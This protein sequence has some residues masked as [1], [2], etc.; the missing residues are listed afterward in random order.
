M[1][2]KEISIEEI[3]GYN[4]LIDRIF[5]KPIDKFSTKDLKKYRRAIWKLS[6]DYKTDHIF[7]MV[8]GEII[9][10]NTSFK[11]WISIFISITSIVIALLS[12]Y[13]SC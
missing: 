13:K 4:E 7:S 9:E 3:D 12:F 10:R 8:N 1:K 2:P 5:S 11:F 6:K